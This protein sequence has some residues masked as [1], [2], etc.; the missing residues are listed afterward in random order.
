MCSLEMA[1]LTISS[2]G[3]S[4]ERSRQG[5]WRILSKWAASRSSSGSS[6]SSSILKISDQEEDDLCGPT[7][8]QLHRPRS[9]V[10][11][12]VQRKRQSETRPSSGT[13]LRTSSGDKSAEPQ[14]NTPG[15]SGSQSFWGTSYQRG[16]DSS[17][18]RGPVGSPGPSGLQS[19]WS[20]REDSSVHHRASSASSARA[21]APIAEKSAPKVEPPDRFSGARQPD[22]S[23]Q[24]PAGSQPMR[25]AASTPGREEAASEPRDKRS[26]TST[27]SK[28]DK[29]R[30]KP[31]VGVDRAAQGRRSSPISR[32]SN[33]RK[34]GT[35]VRRPVGY[36]ALQEIARFRSSTQT[37]IPRLSFARVVREIMQCHATGGHDL[38]IQRLA[39]DALQQGSEAVLV[40]LLEGS[41][42]IAHSARRVT[43]MPRDIQTLLTII[44]NYGSLQQSLTERH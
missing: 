9:A 31:V 1:H 28:N 41:N 15:P 13:L 16:E 25:S 18:H 4:R 20:R 24:H 32:P 43:I 44:R 12:S 30:A 6:L 21:S 33:Q 22:T 35:A 8:P 39:L 23:L 26:P 40:A 38:R 3:S 19:F 34:L 27:S 42:L 37:L 17:M 2:L 14:H 7:E 11:Q 5:K 36:R 10:R 29:S